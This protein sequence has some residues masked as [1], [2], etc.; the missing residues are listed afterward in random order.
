MCNRFLKGGGQGG[1][2]ISSKQLFSHNRLPFAFHVLSKG[3]I[4]IHISIYLYALGHMQYCKLD[5][6]YQLIFLLT[7]F[8]SDASG[9]Q[10]Q[11]SFHIRSKIL[12]AL[13]FPPSPPSLVKP[14]QASLQ[15]LLCAQIKT[16][17]YIMSSLGILEESSPNM[18][19]VYQDC[20]SRNVQ[21]ASMSEN[22]EC[23]NSNSLRNLSQG[24]TF[25]KQSE[26]L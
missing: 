1:S 4:C 21:P 2:R 6:Q 18:F 8:F 14:A 9:K 25:Q 22:S 11:D 26:I 20:P 5:F 19:Q 24:V 13:L 10:I 7:L 12:L 17:Y 23:W 16:P 3:M 15:F